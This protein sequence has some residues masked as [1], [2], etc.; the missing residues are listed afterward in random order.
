ML[1]NSDVIAEFINLLTFVLHFC[2]LVF[3]NGTFEKLL[4]SDTFCVCVKTAVGIVVEKKDIA[5]DFKI[6][7]HKG[8]KNPKLDLF[9]ILILIS[10]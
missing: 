10:T 1:W 3:I 4:F 6:C 9:K 5:Y 8:E 2:D 7:M